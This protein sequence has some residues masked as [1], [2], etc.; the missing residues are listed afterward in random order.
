[1]IRQVSAHE[2]RRKRDA[3]GE[4]HHDVTFGD[5]PHGGIK[6]FCGTSAL[7]MHL[8]AAFGPSGLEDVAQEL[9]AHALSCRIR[10]GGHMA[11]MADAAGRAPAARC[12]M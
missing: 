10:I 7:A 9:C 1:M 6:C 8:G 12:R 11:Y 3:A 2:N 4:R 5:K